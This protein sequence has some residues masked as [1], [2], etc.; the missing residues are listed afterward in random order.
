MSDGLGDG[1]PEL[2]DVLALDGEDLE[3]VA[4]E[5][6]RELEALEVLGG[7]ARDGDVVVVD[8]ELDVQ[9]LRDGEAGGLGVVALLLGAV[10]AEAED[11]LVAVGEG[12][13]VDEGPDVAKAAGGELDA[14]G[15]AELGVTWKL[16]VGGAVV[17][18]V[19]GGD[20]ALECGKEVL[21]RDAVTWWARCLWRC[22][23]RGTA[24]DVPA[25][26]KTTG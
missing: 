7:M 10:G 18:E 25:S 13:A 1:A 14:R 11:G 22:A 3:A 23:A 4:L 5:S 2:V 26:S 12:D 8:E 16:R 15:E 17:E 20:V 21:G 19:F 9:V 6:L 24:R